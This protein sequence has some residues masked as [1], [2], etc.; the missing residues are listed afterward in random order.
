MMNKFGL[1]K[2]VA[3]MAAAALVASLGAALSTPET[4]VEASGSL[5]AG[6]E[7][8]PLTPSRL[9][10]TR[11]PS[12]DTS[13]RGAKPIGPAA[14]SF[15]L[16]VAGRGGVPKNNVLAVAVSVVAVR[17][18]GMGWI[19]VSPSG[20]DAGRSSMLNYM[21]GDVVP[22]FA[23]VGVGSDGK[24][25]LSSFATV[26]SEMHVVVDVYGWIA[27]SSYND[28]DDAGAR[29]EVMSPKRFLDTRDAQN[30]PIGWRS[31]RPLNAGETARIKIRGR[32]GV[33][34]SQDISGVIVN[35]VGVNASSFN[36]LALT[37]APQPGGPTTSSGNYVPG[38]ARAMM[39]IVPVAPDGTIAVTAGPGGSIN[40]V[41]DVVGY[42]KKGV[43]ASSSAGRV[44]PLDSPFRAL[45]TRLD[46]FGSAP[47]GPGV[48]EEWSFKKFS[49]SVRVGG[50][51]VKQSGLFANLTGTSL[52][53]A[54]GTYLTAEPLVPS[55]LKA[56]ASTS[57]LNINITQHAVPNQV[58]ITYGDESQIQIYN[59]AG[60]MHYILDV[61]AVVL[62]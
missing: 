7:Y 16:Q 26:E 27:T 61:Y 21:P 29:V 2:T 51:Q 44:V 52:Q 37:P 23:I 30:T 15:K 43:D 9:L 11:D 50:L 34:N 13:P 47:I 39:S 32:H 12:N 19:A 40:A 55:S 58:L 5:R 59:R 36:W 4:P 45:D 60:T 38:N 18:G 22:N 20:S 57:S 24:I 33:P 14:P 42:L 25:N 10:D 54:Y 62:D 56:E 41:L 28:V 49:K 8:F 17:P 46:E 3:V 35:L 53:G 1:R 6:G 31:S 48:W